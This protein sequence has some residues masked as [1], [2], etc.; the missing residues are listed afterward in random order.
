M[1]RGLATGLIF[2]A[3]YSIIFAVLGYYFLGK[4]FMSAVIGFLIGSIIEGAIRV[5]KNPATGRT[6][7]GQNFQDIFEY[8]RQQTQRYDF[9]TQLLALSAYVMKSDGKVVKSELNFVKSFLA[10]QFGPNFN[11]QHLQTLK[12]F[13]DAPS[14]PIEEICADIRMRG[15]V[16]IRIQLLHYL[17]GIARADGDVS[18]VEVQTLQR[19]AH[20]LQVPPMDFRSVQGMFKQNLNADYEVL[21]I[22][23]AASDEEV[24]KWL[25]A[26]IPIKLL[27]WAKNIKKEPKRNSSAFKKPMTISR[28][29]E[30]FKIFA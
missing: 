11:T 9:P 5:R 17:F 1:S 29:R 23:V 16:E 7:G 26:I 2:Y 22:D 24:K 15:Q 6:A 20:L 25:C 8:Y 28:R 10:Q 21:G 4:T 18:D 14:I 13:L 30:E 12:H 3:V 27:P 19:L